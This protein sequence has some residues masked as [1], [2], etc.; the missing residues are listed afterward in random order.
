MG[1]FTKNSDLRCLGFAAA[2]CNDL[3]SSKLPVDFAILR[4][5]GFFARFE[6]KRPNLLGGFRWPS[7][8]SGARSSGTDEF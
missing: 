6:L 3:M 1:D 8:E 7:G 2:R 5:A 4:C